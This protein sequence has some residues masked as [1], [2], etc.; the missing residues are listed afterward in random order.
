[1]ANLVYSLIE[2][3]GPKELAIAKVFTICSV[4]NLANKECNLMNL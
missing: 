4:L 3:N 2:E 1:M